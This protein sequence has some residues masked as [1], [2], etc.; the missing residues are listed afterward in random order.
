M[1]DGRNGQTRRRAGGESRDGAELDSRFVFGSFWALLLLATFFVAGPWAGFHGVLLG[2]VGLLMLSCPPLVA[3][4]RLWWILA[5]VFVL[6]AAATFLPAGWFAIPEWRRNLADLGVETG[7]LVVIQ[8][9]LAAETL[10]LFA[11][12]LF[13]GLW[14]AGHRPSPSRVLFWALAFTVG[15]AAYAILARLMQDSSPAGGEAHFGFFPNRNH[16]ATY[17]AMGSICGL[18]SVLQAL[19]DKRFLAMIVALAGT[20]VCL[21]AVAAWSVSRSGV[22]LVAIG[23][24]GWFPMLGTRYLGKHG[25]RALGLI[26]LAATGL[27]FIADSGV[28]ARLTKTVEQTNLAINPADSKV[29]EGGKAEMDSARDLDFRI[30]TALDTLGLIR[31][32]PW[33]GIGAGQYH[34]IFPQYRKLTAVA[35]DSDNYHPESDWLWLASETGIPA[36][37]AL[38][39]LVLLASRKSLRDILTGRERAVRSA[40]LIA[41]LLVPIHGLFDVPGHRITLAWS[42]A[43]LFALSLRPPAADT[44]L[45][46]PRVWPFRLAALALLAASAFLIRAEW[47]G[48]PQPAFTAV[49]KASEQAL[50]LYRQDQVLQKAALAKG[51][52]YQ[53]VPSQDLLEKALTLLQPATRIVPLDRDLLRLQG[54]F[55][56]QFDDKFELADRSFAIERALD[57]TW[58][59]GPLRQA[60]AWA[61]LDPQ[62]TAGLWTEALR[63][64]DSLDLLKPGGGHASRDGALQRIRQFAKGKPQIEGFIPSQPPK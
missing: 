37:L 19:R 3:L 4:P 32:F 18:G 38:A 51:E 9:R 54:V 13:T 57:P 63:R 48:G 36:T 27:F 28:K 52:T 31:E 22:V 6:A 20:C 26:A 59:A 15:V 43:F 23:G 25:L 16:T 44:P 5:G 45:D 2:C 17:L 21:W 62:R 35:N 60:E 34:Y 8:S 7:S 30:P 12:T 11:I 58:V 46:P 39:A 41:A 33:T 56:L 29:L 42:A 1:S 64:A 14:L 55:A 49:P 24:L 40:C 61:T 50:D 53:P 10:A 47:W